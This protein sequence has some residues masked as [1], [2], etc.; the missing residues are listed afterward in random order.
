MFFSL[1]D[2]LGVGKDVEK[3]DIAIV[4]CAACVIIMLGQVG[5]TEELSVISNPWC[6]L[7]YEFMKGEIYKA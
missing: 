5:L 4:G 7:S 3:V 2:I 1:S 6:I